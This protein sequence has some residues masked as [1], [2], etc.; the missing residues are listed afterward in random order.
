MPFGYIVCKLQ[1]TEI[2]KLIQL[3]NSEQEKLQGPVPQNL[4]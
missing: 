1:G 3:P 2:K 4:N